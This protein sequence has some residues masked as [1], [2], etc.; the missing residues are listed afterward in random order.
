[1][2][3]KIA[4]ISNPDY[5]RMISLDNDSAMDE[6]VAD[7]V[8]RTTMTITHG[9]AAPVS[10]GEIMGQLRYVAQSGEEITALLIA[11]RDVKAQPPA[12]DIL[13]YMPFL[14]RL[15]DPLVQALAVVL[16]VLVL[17]LIVAII[18][19]RISKQRRRAK[20]YQVRRKEEL[21]A[22]RAYNRRRYSEAR[23]RKE[24]VR[25]ERR[26]KWERRFD[27]AYDFEDFDD[28]EDYDD[29]DEDFEDDERDDYDL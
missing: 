11:S 4:R 27:D 23:A 15:E 13:T 8:T 22:V 16:A 6:A 26:E 25:R 29:D 28:D 12:F 14:K 18:Y 3:M 17:L 9:M 19:R 7:F 5:V 10:E 2:A 1:M 21:Q 20:I 24:A